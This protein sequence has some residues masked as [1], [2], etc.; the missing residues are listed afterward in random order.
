MVLLLFNSVLIQMLLLLNVIYQ[1]YRLMVVLSK[2]I[3]IRDSKK[4]D[5]MGE[6]RKRGDSEEM[7]IKI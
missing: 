3:S 6:A 1:V 2:P 4:A 5:N 7:I